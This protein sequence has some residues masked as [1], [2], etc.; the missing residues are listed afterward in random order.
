MKKYL[1]LCFVICVALFTQSC[2]SKGVQKLTIT[3]SLEPQKYFLDKIVGDKIQVECLLANGAN[4]EN[5][6]PSMENLMQIE[7]SA[8]YIKMGN[9]GF[10]QVLVDKLKQ[11]NSSLK[12]YDASKGIEGITGTHDCCEHHGHHHHHDASVDPHTWTSV[13]NAKIIA[14]NM[15]DVVL[16]VDEANK[17]FY[18]ANYDKLVAS[19]D[20]L[21]EYATKK[22]ANVENRS[23]LVWHPSLSYFARDYGLNQITIGQI[24]K[25]LSPIQ[26]QEKINKARNS[27]AK[28]FFFQKEY[29]SRQASVLNEEV[30]TTMITINPLSYEWEDEIRR[31]VDEIA[32]K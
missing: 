28:I 14:K 3:V 31:I 5:Y 2:G 32:T 7:R 1:L 13:K 16:A 9:V 21:D 18:K 11:N 19:L 24:G 10:E 23:F 17:D 26:L 20:S 29:D 4:P 22:L 8:A 27:N 6:E 15:Y 25:E 12:V 30:G